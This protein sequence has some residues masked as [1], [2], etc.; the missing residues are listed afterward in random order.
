MKE[1]HSMKLFTV[2]EA[3]QCLPELE[4]WIRELQE[5]REWILK[6]E[7]EIDALELVADKDEDGISPALDKKIQAYKKTVNRFYGTLDK[8]HGMGCFLKD[9]TMGLVDFY[10]L[11]EGRVV[12]L[13][14][15][16]GEKE[17]TSWHEVG[18]GYTYRQPIA[19]DPG[20]H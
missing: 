3:N 20:K 4:K 12:Y 7:V 15:R 1:A 14:W 16:L 6:Q 11:H 5:K 2:Q 18:R 17:I 9:I 19:S 13:C 10:T 8:I